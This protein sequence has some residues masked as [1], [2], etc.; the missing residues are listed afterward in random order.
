MTGFSFKHLAI[1]IIHGMMIIIAVLYIMQIQPNSILKDYDKLKEILV[2]LLFMLS[3]IIGMI[4]DF[5]ADTI[6]VFLMKKDIIDSPVK[7][8]LT[9]GEDSGIF[10]AH[11]GKIFK[12][13]FN[14]AQKNIN[15][16]VYNC[17]KYITTEI[18]NIQYNYIFQ[19]AKNRVFR[20]C[21]TNQMEQVDS[22]FMLYIFCRNIVVT[23]CI[24]LVLFLVSDIYNSLFINCFI[25]FEFFTNTVIMLVLAIVFFFI[26]K[27][28]SI[29]K[30]NNILKIEFNLMAY[31]IIMYIVVI[32][33]IILVLILVTDIYNSQLAYQIDSNFILYNINNKFLNTYLFFI[34]TPSLLN[35]YFGYII[36]HVFF[37]IILLS[38]I[39]LFVFATKRYGI[40]Y[41]RIVLGSSFK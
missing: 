16:E 7:N 35:I 28:Y 41:V 5:I 31:F 26:F 6:E 24:V 21:N 34:N 12:D 9:K 18:E 36:K 10:L 3:Y 30:D 4:I 33:C 32:L 39:L 19:V 23:L 11:Y 13:L 25:V 27:I 29:L 1:Q 40:Y 20:E 17:D 37:Y 15:R 2:I 8:L 14:T 38:L 22:Y